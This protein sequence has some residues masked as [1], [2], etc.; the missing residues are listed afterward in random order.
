MNLEA[1]VFL[2]VGG[3]ED[4]EEI[5]AVKR[6]D[7]VLRGRGYRGLQITTEV[8]AEETHLSVGASALWRGLRE[9]YGKL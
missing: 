1:S 9:I 2:S 8:F 5:K 4:E 3:L 6:F 7:T